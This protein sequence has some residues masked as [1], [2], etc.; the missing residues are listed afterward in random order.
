MLFGSAFG[1]VFALGF[2]SLNVN[3]GHYRLA[4]C[5]SLLIGVFNLFLYKLAPNVHSP[6]EIAAYLLGGP[7][8]IVC[9]MKA[10][11][12][13]KAWLNRGAE[14]REL[15]K[16]QRSFATAFEEGR[17]SRH[18][19]ELPGGMRGPVRD[20]EAEESRGS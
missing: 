16:L 2:Q 12:R 19:D 8:G 17:R 9:A 3:A 7:I 10:H 4:F 18:Y 11:A 20:Y 14:Q 15:D 5:T 13:M 1:V 6:L